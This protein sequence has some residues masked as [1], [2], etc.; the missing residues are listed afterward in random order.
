MP[1]SAQSPELLL[2][3]AKAIANRHFRRLSHDDRDDLAQVAVIAALNH[4]DRWD[5]TRDTSFTTFITHRM[6]GEMVDY[7]RTQRPGG[8]DGA[9]CLHRGGREWTAPIDI[10]VHS[11]DERLNVPEEDAGTLYDIVA[12]AEGDNEIDEYLSDRATDA[13]HDAI[14]CLPDRERVAV[15]MCTSVG[16]SQAYV[17]GLLGVT[18]SRVSQLVAKGHSR[19]ADM[20]ELQELRAA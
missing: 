7:L 18:G 20:P 19:L 17:A 5:E 4:A 6:R 16:L 14:D 3:L 2:A 10:S 8:R 9:M 12:N 15:T 13:I 11:L 1:D